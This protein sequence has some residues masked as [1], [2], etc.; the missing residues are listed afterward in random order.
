MPAFIK[1]PAQER[2]WEKAKGLA[3]EAGH[4]EDWPYITG[5]YKKLHGGRVALQSKSVADLEREMHMWFSGQEDGHDR[6]ITA[7]KRRVIEAQER[8]KVA[9]IPQKVK[10]QVDALL[11]K[12]KGKEVPDEEVH[13]IAEKGGVSP[14]DLE[15]Y[16][17]S[18][19][20][21][22]LMETKMARQV[23]TRFL[24]R[25]TA[26]VMTDL[27]G[28]SPRLIR[29]AKED[30]FKEIV[31]AARMVPESFPEPKALR[32]LNL[33]SLKLSNIISPIVSKKMW[34]WVKS[35]DSGSIKDTLE[36][37]DWDTDETTVDVDIQ[38][39][40]L[41]GDPDGYYVN[42]DVTYSVEYPTQIKGYIEGRIDM[43]RDIK[44]IM[45][46]VNQWVMKLHHTVPWA[47]I[48]KLKERMTDAIDEQYLI[49][50]DQWDMGVL[51]G[52]ISEAVDEFV[53]DELELK[54][55]HN[56]DADLDTSRPGLGIDNIYF[57]DSPDS[58]FE[59]GGL[60]LKLVFTA[61]VHVEWDII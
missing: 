33:Y 11:K 34:E 40:G 24:A 12:Y 42:T 49:Q 9:G 36:P 26:G 43:A 27:T 13:A 37:E 55:S 57:N 18:L 47:N 38:E 35:M 5:I 16:I 28:Y 10:D 14:H 8:R 15:S 3:E 51:D 4:K 44:V 2:L 61:N 1:T 20:S 46:A 60:S 17:Y 39:S 23:A 25:K 7:H 31:L 58:K 52:V 32:L 21:E 41:R 56:S 50:Y 29:E 48:P 6:A 53:R 19:A 22:H 45:L 59:S 54:A 30:F